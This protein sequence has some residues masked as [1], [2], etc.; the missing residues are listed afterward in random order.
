[1]LT[2][3]L[4]DHNFAQLSEV[5]TSLKH[6]LTYQTKFFNS[7]TKRWKYEKHDLIDYTSNSI[8][9]G[10]VPYIQD[11]I[12]ASLVVDQRIFPTIELQ[13]PELSIDLFDYQMDYLSKALQERRMIVKSSTGSGKS[14]ILAAII[15]ALRSVPALI[16]APNKSIM[17]QLRVEL[18]KLI[19]G[20]DLGQ[21]SGEK[22]DIQHQCV[23][24]LAG[25]LLKL[26][27]QEIQRFKVLLVDEVHTVAAQQA[28]DVILNQNAPYRFGFSATPTG[29]SDGKD[30]VVQGLI[31]PI[32]ELI[33]RKTLV[34][35]GYLAHTGVKFHRGAWEGN[36][37][38][39]E[40]LLVVNN[41]LR[42]DLI[43]KIVDNSKASSVLILVRRIDHGEILQKMFG[44]KSIFISGEDGSDIR[45]EVRQGVK[46]GKYKIL[47]ASK[48]F[49]AGIDLPN[50]E[51]GVYVAAGKSTIE[52]TQ[53]AGRV[54][55]AWNDLAKT[56]VD[57]YDSYCQVL[58]DHS[59]ARL[60][61][62]KKQGLP[63]E[64]IG[65]PPGMEETLE[66]IRDNV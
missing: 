27:I 36:Y 49:S 23:I 26:S 25:S 43:K 59:K 65:F 5:T 61:E 63:V 44:S 52:T 47:I 20:L 3:T 51:L 38:V 10:L 11:N 50:L 37:H 7:R 28:H 34:S 53:A 41:P 1:M 31:G 12:N 13:V 54:G 42:N 14:V 56:W 29:R 46:N 9:T 39:L 15:S 33:D 60:I 18:P 16:L 2:I 48:I 19:P 57:I 58:E 21:I 30:L 6:I 4:L 24:G 66:R 35:Q 64:F 22:K 32:V 55:R 8:Y 62:Y 40:D 45:E 17:A